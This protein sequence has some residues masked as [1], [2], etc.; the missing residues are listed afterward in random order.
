MINYPVGV[1][2]TRW[3]RV[4]QPCIRGGLGF[5]ERAIGMRHQDGQETAP[6]TAV[7][8]LP[9]RGGPAAPYRSRRPRLDHQRLAQPRGGSA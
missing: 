1:T 2:P 6:G 3:G 4:T 8:V 9:C 5:I 7:V